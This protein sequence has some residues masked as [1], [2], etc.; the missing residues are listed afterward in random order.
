MESKFYFPFCFF[1]CC[2][3]MYIL[4]DCIEKFF[5][6][7]K[8]IIFK[9]IY[10]QIFRLLKISSSWFKPILKPS[11]NPISNCFFM[12]SSELK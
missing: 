8:K 2:H 9:S 3:F 1:T 7:I 12:S 5:I 6:Q 10:Y 11:S 4:K